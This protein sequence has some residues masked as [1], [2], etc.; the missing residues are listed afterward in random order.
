[1][2]VGI[3][4]A[5]RHLRI[6]DFDGTS[7]EDPWLEMMIPA[8]SQAVLLWLKDETRAYVL[9]VDSSGDVILD[10]SGDPVVEED[11]HGPVV[12]P[13]VKAAVLVELASQYRFRE[14]E[15]VARVPADWGHGYTLSVGA[16]SLLTPLRRSTVA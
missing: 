11:S 8:V 15:G 7:P 5:R 2:L 12:K 13:V 14:G 4:D 6:D 10:S 1:M 9:A 16:T 3:E